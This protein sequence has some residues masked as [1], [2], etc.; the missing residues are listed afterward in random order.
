[1]IRLHLAFCIA[2]EFFL[3]YN[4]NS[5]TLIFFYIKMK[6]KSI[7]WDKQKRVKISLDLPQ[8]RVLYTTENQ[9]A[10]IVFNYEDFIKAY[11]KEIEWGPYQQGDIKYQALIE[12]IKK[13]ITKSDEVDIN[14]L[15]K[16]LNV[17]LD[18]HFN[19]VLYPFVKKGK[20]FLYDVENKSYVDFFIIRD[21]GVY[22]APLMA[23]GSFEFKL[24]NGKIFLEESWIS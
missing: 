5:N 2:K 12:K 23:H 4:E 17:P 19:R 7:P 21:Y 8:K 14:A 13:E 3:S 16:E 24:P 18:F 1:L 15:A 9:V 6:K 20:I 11:E 22:A 10:K